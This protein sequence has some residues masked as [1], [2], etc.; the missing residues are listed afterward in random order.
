MS[1]NLSTYGVV[2]DGI[3]DNLSAFNAAF[4]AISSTGGILYMPPGNFY[5][6][7]TLTPPANVV[8]QGEGC[9]TTTITVPTNKTAILVNATVSGANVNPI[10]FRDFKINT[11]GTKTCGDGIQIYPST[12]ESYFTKISNVNIYNQMNGINIVNG[13]GFKIKDCYLQNNLTTGISIADNNLPD[14]G[15]N[16]IEN[17]FIIN[18]QSTTTPVA[19]NQISGGGSKIHNNKIN[20]GFSYAYV[21][22]PSSGVNTNDIQFVNNSCENMISGG[23]SIINVNGATAWGCIQ[24]LGNQFGGIH[25]GHTIAVNGAIYTKVMVND[26]IVNYLTGSYTGTYGI[27]LVGV[28]DAIVDGNALWGGTGGIGILF[29]SCSNA[30]LGSNSFVGYSTNFEQV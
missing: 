27:A 22:S 4:A 29:A 7:D 12:G 25:S 6:S 28:T 18:T 2:G 10:E 19:I 14:G 23:V 1:I 26:N 16:L 9:E 8:L 13:V 11:V 5:V 30:V 17:N 15:D 21:V 24:I 20:G 3:T